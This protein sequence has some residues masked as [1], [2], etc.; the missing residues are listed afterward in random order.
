MEILSENISNS[1]AN[2]L[3]DHLHLH[4]AVLDWDSEVLPEEA[5]EGFDMI[6]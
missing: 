5:K 3:S 1:S 2:L 6:V 4:P